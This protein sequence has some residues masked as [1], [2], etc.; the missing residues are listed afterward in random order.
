MRPDATQGVLIAGEW[1]AGPDLFEHRN[2]ARPND[3]PRLISVGSAD[4]AAA[5]VNA[6]AGA[7]RDWRR[8]AALT[9]GAL[10]GRFADL[11]ERDHERV[12][13]L[14]VADVGKAIRDARAEVHRASEMARF[15]AHD[16]LRPSGEVY[17]PPPGEAFLHTQRRPVGVVGV[18]TPWN[19]P[20]LIPVW[21]LTS[22]LAWGNA[23]VWN[24]AGIASPSAV[25]V[26]ELLT[27]AGL[28]PGVVNLV[29][30][31]GRVVGAALVDH[32]EVAAITF[33]GS[34]SVGRSIAAVAAP[35]GKKIQA[36]LG[37]NNAA[38]V[39]ADADIEHAAGCIVRAAMLSTGQRCTATSRAIVVED[40]YDALLEAIVRKT[41]TLRVG[42]P[43]DDANDLGPLASEKQYEDVGRLPRDR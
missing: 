36:E 29:S 22:A 11:L 20:V 38:L 19:F 26:A 21:K 24:P 15:F 32:R 4:E 33:T 43:E 34:T 17:P 16:V 13:R 14:V 28:P 8:T 7:Q 31:P 12:A 5:A 37:G 41:Q 30:G 40:C 1:R 35:L 6:A 42:D 25:V 23:V 3:P 2:P 27:E 18:I 9:R 10:L 39:L